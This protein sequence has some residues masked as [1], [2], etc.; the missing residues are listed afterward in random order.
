[1][2]LS[3]GGDSLAP[4]LMSWR[5]GAPGA[6]PKTIGRS[7]SRK[8]GGLKMRPQ[9]VGCWWFPAFCWW[10]FGV[11]LASC[12]LPVGFSANPT[13]NGPQ[14]DTR[15]HTDKIRRHN[16][17]RVVGSNYTP[18]KTHFLLVAWLVNRQIPKD[19]FRSPFKSNQVQCPETQTSSSPKPV[20]WT[21]L[22][23]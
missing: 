2:F 5:S 4:R 17:F 20:L 13:K 12:W 16:L 8:M 19:V 3:R 6:Q 18:A 1:M 22:K 15:L 7:T 14:K 21:D 23:G 9:T 11:A 10:P